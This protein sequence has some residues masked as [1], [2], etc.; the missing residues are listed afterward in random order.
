MFFYISEHPLPPC[1]SLCISARTG[2]NETMAKF[3]YIWPKE[4]DCDGF[5]N[6][7]Q[8][9]KLCVGDDSSPRGFIDPQDI[10]GYHTSRI[11]KRPDVYDQLSDFRC[12]TQLKVDPNLGYKL[13]IGDYVTENC[14]M[15]CFPNVTF[16]DP[17]QVKNAQIWTFSWSILG[18]L[19]CLFTLTTF[20]IDR[21]RFGY[22][23]RPI[24]YLTVC[25]GVVTFMLIIGFFH[26]EDIACNPVTENAT[27]NYF[28]ASTV[29]QGTLQVI[30]T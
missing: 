2:C 4:F 10:D 11:P 9:D 7:N 20:L 19:S 23:E 1:Q 8:P 12:P 30:K 13:Q 28:T 17:D 5:P 26:D 27:A 25:F 6:S 22:P 29:K 14:G 16:F 24:V 15:P 18:F 3:G 21:S